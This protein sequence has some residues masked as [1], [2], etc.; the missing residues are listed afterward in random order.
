MSRPERSGDRHAPVFL[1]HL[2]DA[3][4]VFLGGDE[5]EM[6]ELRHRMA[7]RVVDRPLRDLA[8]VNVR[9]GDA[10]RQRRDDGRVHLGPVA[11]REDEV[12]LAP[13][14]DSREADRA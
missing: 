1:A 5:V 6:A 11:D 14:V 3:G 8:A 13:S 12:G 4:G 10:E 2:S 7:E 9:G